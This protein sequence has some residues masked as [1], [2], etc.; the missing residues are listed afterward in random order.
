M[1]ALPAVS[2][3][4]EADSSRS[5]FRRKTRL[6][7]QADPARPGRCDGAGLRSGRLF[8]AGERGRFND[9]MLRGVVGAQQQG[10][11][12]NKLQYWGGAARVWP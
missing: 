5:H 2:D 1:P 11:S 3:V 12:V 8:V 10:G 4:P 9:G 7:N 6:K